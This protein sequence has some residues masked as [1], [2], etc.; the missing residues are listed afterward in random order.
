MIRFGSLERVLTGPALPQFHSR[1]MK[2]MYNAPTEPNS[3]RQPLR[4]AIVGSGPGGFYTT[5]R[6]FK[7][8]E[9]GEV[10]VDMFERFPIPHGLVRYGVAPDHPEVKVGAKLP[11]ELLRGRYDA[12]VLAYGSMRDK[13]LSVLGENIAGVV[14]ARSFVNWYNG[15][16]DC[17]G[18]E[19]PD[20][21]RSDTAVIF[22]Q[23]NVALDL[24]RILLTPIDTLAKTDITSS[25]LEALSKSTIHH[26]HI[27]GRRGPL[28]VSF[29]AKELRE[30]FLL[31]DT[32]LHIDTALL[33]SQ[34]ELNKEAVAKSRSLM[35]LMSLLDKG[36]REN[37]AKFQVGA[38]K[39]CHFTFLRSPLE[40]RG[41]PA[42]QKVILGVNVLEG[43]PPT[44]TLTPAKETIDCGLALRAIGYQA[45]PMPNL[46]FDY[47][48]GKIPN[49]FGRVSSSSPESAG[50]YVSGWLKTGP[51]GVIATTVIHSHET[52]DTIRADFIAG[53]LSSGRPGLT[54]ANLREAGLMPTSYADWKRLEKHEFDAGLRFNKP[55]EKVVEVE[56]MLRI[57]NA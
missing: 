8:F 52:A 43:M 3:G 48:S 56:E 4:V 44:A 36:V 46:P 19:A 55:R 42:L 9:V 57:I 33:S 45:L 32:K 15:S 29:T 53:K 24:A 11:L 39:S 47:R 17:L 50:I 1:V 23:G 6:L 34:L 7:K 14:S 30:M 10:K 25:S 20:L 38:P 51:V 21:T 26:V 35:R 16:P 37:N 22:G 2:R 49:E 12:L 54:L 18:W 28:Q 27:I 13:K 31:P 41:D 40:F 5:D